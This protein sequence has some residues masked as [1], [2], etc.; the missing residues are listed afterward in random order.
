MAFNPNQ[1]LL[2]LTIHPVLWELNYLFQ[3]KVYKGILIGETRVGLFC[4]NS[5]LKDILGE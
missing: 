3:G 5:T 2:T 1:V 4:L